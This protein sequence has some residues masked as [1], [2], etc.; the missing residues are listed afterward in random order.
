MQCPKCQHENRN[1]DKFCRECGAKLPSVCPNCGHELDARD[2]FCAECG[3]RLAEGETAPSRTLVPKLEDMHAQLQSLI[4]DTL[5]QKYLTAEQQVTGENRLITALFADISGFTPL[6]A[7]QSSETMFQLVQDCFKQLVSVVANYEGSI[8]GFRGDGLL[9]LFGAPI[10]HENDA[11]RAILAAIDMREAMQGRQLEVS[12]GINTALM[13]V[14]DIQTQLH[15]E[16]TAYGTD[17]ILASRLEEAAQP[18]QIL[19]GSGTHRL[20]RRAFDFRTVSSLSL[21]GFPHPL[22]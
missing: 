4:P 14:G 3:T 12:I 7:T 9:A 17:I 21:Q 2:K 1:G 16:Y 5:A 22:P 15:R 10:L 11:E 20:T 19:V 13:T 8:S 18:G 6:S